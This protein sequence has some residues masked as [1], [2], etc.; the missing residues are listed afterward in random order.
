[1]PCLLTQTVAVE[2]PHLLNLML[3]Y[4]ACHRSRLLGHPEPTHR[5]ALF[6]QDVFPALR[7]TLDN[8]SNEEVSNANL[9]TA[10]M[11]ASLEI[12]SPSSFG[13][14]IPWQ[15]HLNVAREIIRA[16]AVPHSI[17]RKDPVM[18]FLTRWLAYLDVLGSLSGRRNEEPLFAGDYWSSSHDEGMSSKELSLEDDDCDDEDDYTI[19]CLLGFTTRCISILAQIAL[20]ARECAPERINPNTGQI[21]VDWRPG[22][23]I[24]KRADRLRGDLDHART[25]EQ[26]QCAHHSPQL[27]KAQLIQQASQAP[28]ERRY[29]YVH[30]TDQDAE[31]SLASNSA[32]HW[33]GMVHLLRRVHNLPRS[34]PEVQEAV[35]EIVKVLS[36]IRERGSAEACLL[37]PTFTA[38]VE[39]ES[40]VDRAEVLARITGAEGLGMCQV[41]RARKV[42]EEAWRTGQSWETFVSGEFF[43]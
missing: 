3:A 13:V 10:I 4:S 37:F 14:S 33:A 22:P 8:V 36:R 43:G 6:V 23:D 34:H 2:N 18:Y 5:I 30:M 32:F 24:L 21:N 1:V 11:L 42:M 40:E 20:L 7:Q 41:S 29:S 26:K 17:S 25:H 35:H 12:I 15:D 16:R 39:A 28:P 38:G 31:E 19:D 9:A 27:S